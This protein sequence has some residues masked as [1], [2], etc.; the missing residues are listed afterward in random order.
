MELRCEL[1]AAEILE[2]SDDSSNDWMAREG[3]IVP[4]HENVQRSRLRVDSRRWL[5]SKLMPRKYGDRITAEI[6]GDP[7]APVVT[8]IELVPIAPVVRAARPEEL[9]ARDG[10]DEATV[11]PLRALPSR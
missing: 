6:A 2:I 3:R 10:G 5:L 1:L 4:D 8:R 9:P 7:H 11:T